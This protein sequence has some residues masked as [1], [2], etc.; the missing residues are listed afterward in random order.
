M[1]LKDLEINAGELGQLDEV[2]AVASI[3]NT[4]IS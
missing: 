3:L 4:R 2:S 1:G